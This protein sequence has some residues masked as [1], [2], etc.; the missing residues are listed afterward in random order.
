MK[1]TEFNRKAQKLIEENGGYVVKTIITNKAGTSDMLACIEGRFCAIEGKLPYN[2]L[3]ELQKA[4]HRKIIDAGGL[5]FCVKTLV[6][7]QMVIKFAKVGTIQE[8]PSELNL[9]NFNL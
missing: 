9:N 7:V 3:S 5:A 4:Q 2:K 1:E 8:I 6:E